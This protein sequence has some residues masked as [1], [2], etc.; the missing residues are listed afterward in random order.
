MYWSW[1]QSERIQIS[2]KELNG[3][4]IEGFL[5]VVHMH[6]CKHKCDGCPFSLKRRDDS[7]F[8]LNEETIRDERTTIQLLPRGAALKAGGGG[9]GGV[10]NG[11][12]CL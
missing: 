6:T 10:R 3:G 12:V 5:S 9:G 8:A 4:N 11:F 2:K 7:Y 1:G